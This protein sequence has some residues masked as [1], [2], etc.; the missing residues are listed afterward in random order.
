MA[1]SRMF[2]VEAR[3]LLPLLFL[4]VL[5]VS[6]SV[7]DSFRVSPAIAPEEAARKKEVSF[8]TADQG[9]RKDTPTFRLAADGEEWAKIAEEWSLSLPDYPY[10]PQHE[11][12]VFVLHADVNDIYTVP[13]GDGRL[14]VIVQATPKRDRY[15]VITL[16]ATDV[17]L[18]EGTV[19]WK[20]VDR[21]QNVLDQIVREKTQETI[22]EVEELPQK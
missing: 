12:A 21:K 13:K 8:T 10:Q 1:K 20:L 15:Q 7:Y 16:P 9:E 3:R 4:L 22:S 11:I 5:L 18:E 6:L 14:E 2:V 19:T 17:V